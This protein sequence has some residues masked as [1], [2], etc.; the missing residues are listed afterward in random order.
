MD[1]PVS[2]VSGH[3]GLNLAGTVGHWYLPSQFDRLTRPERVSDW[4]QEAGLL[5]AAPEVAAEGRETTLTLRAAIYRLTMAHINAQPADPA[6][7]DTVN[8]AAAR[9]PVTIR[10]STSGRLTRIGDLGQALASI[11]RE[12]IELLGG[13]DAE[14]MKVCGAQDCTRLYL[15][16]SRRGDRRWCDMRECGNRAKATAY[17]RRKAASA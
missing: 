4:I 5:D 7:L 16:T 3:V 9:P 2:L 6:D 12:T 17:R 11:G 13:P 1:V 15:D 14:R 10:L 8:A